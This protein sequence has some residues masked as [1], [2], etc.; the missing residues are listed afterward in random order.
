LIFAS[1]VCKNTKFNTIVFAKNG[2]IYQVKLQRVDALL[3]AIEKQNFGFDLNGAV[4]A[5]SVFFPFPLC[6][7]IEKRL[8]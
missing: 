4:M 1:K 2:T 6:S 8:V 5:T 3:Q 7:I